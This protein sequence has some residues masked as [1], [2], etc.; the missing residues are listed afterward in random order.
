[1]TKAKVGGHIENGGVPKESGE[2]QELIAIPEAVEPE[3]VEAPKRPTIGHE[4][5]SKQAIK[6][7][8][9]DDKRTPYLELFESIGTF[10]GVIAEGIEAGEDPREGS[11]IIENSVIDVFR[12]FNNSAHQSIWHPGDRG[13]EYNAILA[14]F[15]A[16]GKG[17]YETAK[18]QFSQLAEIGY[19]AT[20]PEVLADD[21]IEMGG[22]PKELDDVE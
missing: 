20:I 15:T 9:W 17:E 14:M 13:P 12:A 3:V 22:D 18:M 1:M 7:A 8:E 4:P 21:F 11:E 2:Q 19:N 10:F 5:W 16:L 6:E